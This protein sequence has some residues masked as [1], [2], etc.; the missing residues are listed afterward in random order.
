ML[1][2]VVFEKIQGDQKVT[3]RWSQSV[4]KSDPKVSQ[5]SGPK[6][7][8]KVVPNVPKSG[9]KVFQILTGLPS[10]STDSQF[11]YP[12]CSRTSYVGEIGF[13]TANATLPCRLGNKTA[14]RDVPEK[15]EI[16]K[17]LQNHWFSLIFIGYTLC[18]LKLVDR[19]NKEISPN[20]QGRAAFAVP[21]SKYF[22]AIHFFYFSYW[23]LKKP[24]FDAKN[25]RFFHQ[26]G[27]DEDEAGPMNLKRN[28]RTLEYYL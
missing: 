8:K 25:D 22:R 1:N 28:K 20:M 10:P 5:K 12:R 27:S 16:F 4:Q 2:G 18:F 24:D 9:P 19:K 7:C 23:N 15:L 11:W 6:V 26:C 14:Q 17:I 3:K 13:G 21:K